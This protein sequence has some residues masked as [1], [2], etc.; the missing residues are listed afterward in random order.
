MKHFSI[1][2]GVAM[3]LV[4]GNVL[5]ADLANA[6]AP[7]VA[8]PKAHSWTGL[9][10]GINVGY[11]FGAYNNGYGGSLTAPSA[12]IAEWNMNHGGYPLSAGV[13]GGGGIGYNHQINSILVLGLEADIQAADLSSSGYGTRVAQ[14]NN[15][16]IAGNN[17]FN[18]DWFGTARGRVGLILPSLSNVLFYGTGGFAYGYANNTYSFAGFSTAVYGQ[19][20]S[21]VSTF[22]NT[23]LGWV[24]GGGI[25]WSPLSFPNWST[26]IEYLYT[27]LGVTNQN[28]FSTYSTSGQYNL[29]GTKANPTSFNT[30]RVG[31]NWHFNP[32]EG[33]PIVAKF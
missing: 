23:Q 20:S 18:I 24:A 30:V 5:A 22:G 9:F 4:S 13:L 26:K 12:N 11:G 14:T 3:S 1:A 33:Q 21:G 31:L 15:A 6:K 2:A 7:V 32:F 19:G 17:Y 27:D 29:V 16:I 10:G 28:L 25:E 8:S